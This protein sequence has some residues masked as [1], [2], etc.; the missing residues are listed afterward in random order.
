M[1]PKRV[2][3]ATFENQSITTAG[4]DRDLWYVAPAD[5]K[6]TWIMGWSFDQISDV[7]DAEEEILRYTSIRGH[8]T[9][10]S[11]GGAVTPNPLNPAD[12]AYGGTVRANDTTIAS[13]GSP[14]TMT[15]HAFNIRIP[16]RVWLPPE[17]WIPVSQ[18]Q[19]SLVLRLMAGPAD[20]L[21]MSSTLWL[22]E[23]G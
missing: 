4:G 2:Y 8:A 1:F 20:D 7:K 23:I 21:T 14:L 9:V 6:I 13:A 18:V 12:T 17:L 22:C 16:E 19:G 11:G 10:G 5:D 3:T 15:A